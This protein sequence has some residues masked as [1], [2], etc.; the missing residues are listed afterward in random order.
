MVADRP[1]ARAAAVKFLRAAKLNR[2]AAR[3]YYRHLHGFASAGKELPEVVQRGLEKAITFG[4]ALRGDYYEFGVFKGHTFWQAQRRA[5]ALGLENMRFFGFDSFEGL[6]EPRGPDATEEQ[7]FYKGQYACSLE[8][9][10]RTL[11]AHGT[12]W[13]TAFLIKGYFADSLTAETRRRYGMGKVAIALVD[14]D[15]YASSIE[16]LRFMGD[17]LIDKSILI[18]DDWSAFDCADDRGQRRALRDF[19]EANPQWSAEEWFQYGAPR[20]RVFIMHQHSQQNASPR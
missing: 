18:M 12:D 19:L 10:R 4:T 15:L 6:P 13:E 7:T 1:A 8:E 14:C 2:L 9:V 17:M 20:G 16:A 3:V 11:H 5:K